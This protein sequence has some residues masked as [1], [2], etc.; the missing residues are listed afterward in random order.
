MSKGIGT[1]LRRGNGKKGQDGQEEETFVDI[2]QILEMGDITLTRETTDTTTFDSVGGYEEFEGGLRSAG[3]VTIKVK[4]KK[5]DPTAILLRSDFD[6]DVPVNYQ[7]AWPDAEHTMVTFLGLVTSYGIA[8]P[9][10]ENI[11]QSFT[12]KISGKPSW[13]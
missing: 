9:L 12:L 5:T 4:Y 2:A 7:I 6:S 3:E 8:T 13:S 10:K 11:T 1:K